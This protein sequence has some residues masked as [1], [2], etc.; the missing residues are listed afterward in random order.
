M[1]VK[2]DISYTAQ[3]AESFLPPVIVRGSSDVTLVITGMAALDGARI[4]EVKVAA[5]NVSGTGLEI[6]ASKVGSYFVATLPGVFFADPGIVTSG[7][8]IKGEGSDAAGTSAAWV[9]G[10]A[11]I[12][13][14]DI[15]TGAVPAPEELNANDYS[16]KG[17]DTYVK[18]RIVDGVQHYCLQ[19]ITYDEEMEAWGA[20]WSGDY[21]L[22]DN[23]TFEEV[24]NA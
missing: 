13:I 8:I 3:N 4:R 23:G 14:L 2:A 22:N 7:L 6:T 24:E 16:L 5:T 12:E 9:L 1:I 21:I 19:T 11:D 17:A 18:S 20:T 10:V 15:A